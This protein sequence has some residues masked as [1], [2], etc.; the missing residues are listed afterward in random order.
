MVARRLVWIAGR[1]VATIVVSIELMNSA[2]ATIPKISRRDGLGSPADG[3]C[4][5]TE[6]SIA[7][8]V[9]LPNDCGDLSSGVV[10]KG[11]ASKRIS[12]SRAV[13][14]AGLGRA[15]SGGP[16]LLPHQCTPAPSAS[17]RFVWLWQRKH[18]FVQ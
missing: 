14:L 11:A 16:Y 10:S 13:V 9:S 8:V 12:P 15:S 1:A 7:T 6:C 3:A 17:A 4:K 2:T 18:Y 5:P